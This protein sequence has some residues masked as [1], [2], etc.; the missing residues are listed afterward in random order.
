MRVNESEG[1][2]A[3]SF[4]ALV[5]AAE[6]APVQNKTRSQQAPVRLRSART[7]K[8]WSLQPEVGLGDRGGG[9]TGAGGAAHAGFDAVASGALGQV[10]RLISRVQQFFRVGG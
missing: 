1:P 10:Q 4:L 6:A 9:R 7:V 5:G 8:P 2:K 3:R